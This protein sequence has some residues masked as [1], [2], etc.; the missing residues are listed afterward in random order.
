VRRW[1]LTLLA[2]AVPL[3][4]GGRS[5]ERQEATGGK[6]GSAGKGGDGASGG[7]AAT[8]GMS[9]AGGMNVGG[10]LAGGSSV[11]GG[12]GGPAG[13]AGGTGA[14]GTGGGS[15]SGGDAG[16]PCNPELEHHRNYIGDLETC[17]RADFSCKEP[18]TGFSNACGCGCEQDA[19]CPPA[20]DC[21]PN[22]RPAPGLECTPEN[23]ARCPLSEELP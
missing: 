9:A 8:G 13:G 21:G 4:C 10:A 19:S 2:I 20:F 22:A 23:L 3:S 17:A 16:M 15:G 18:T 14:A 1:V 5:E 7:T 6:G 11:G 12:A